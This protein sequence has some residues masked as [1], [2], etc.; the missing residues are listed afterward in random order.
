MNIDFD[1]DTYLTS[2][3]L[4]NELVR[5]SDQNFPINS[6]NP[7]SS[8]RFHKPGET[9]YYFGS[10]VF[11][12]RAEVYGDGNNALSVQDHIHEAPEGNYQLF[13]F[14][15]LL[16]DQPELR[17]TYFPS[18]KGGGWNSCQ[19]LREVLESMSISGVIFPS[20]QHDGGVNMSLWPLDNHPLPIPWFKPRES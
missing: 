13:D 20:Q 8:G 7:I 9:T 16:K 6:V 18:E 5:I 3:K 17:E 11:T 15:C 4:N 19:Q 10:G 2:F 12:A 14:N 1:I